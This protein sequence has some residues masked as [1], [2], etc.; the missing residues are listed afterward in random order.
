M[1]NICESEIREDIA[2]FE[3][4]A[5]ENVPAVT[6]EQRNLRKHY[7]RFIGRR[8]QLLAAYLDGRPEAWQDY[9]S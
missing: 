2:Y 9:A 5:D 1:M 3:A 4:K 6:A 8:K 7:L